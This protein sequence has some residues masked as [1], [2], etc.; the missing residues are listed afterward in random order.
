M[1]VTVEFLTGLLLRSLVATSNEGP[2]VIYVQPVRR[3]LV[4]APVVQLVGPLQPI[5]LLGN[6]SSHH[7][8]GLGHRHF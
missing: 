1:K 7:P 3:H 4:E 8:L 5:L 6:D 2:A